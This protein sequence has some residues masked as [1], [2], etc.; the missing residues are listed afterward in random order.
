MGKPTKE[1]GAADTGKTI[2]A[3]FV[4]SAPPTFR[5]AG[6]E[7]NREGFGIALDALTEAQLRAIEGDPDLF[8]E[9]V[10]VPADQLIG[11]VERG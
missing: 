9:R 1:T 10:D 7:F 5:R 4:R 3:I 8:C 11:T 2:A 6:F